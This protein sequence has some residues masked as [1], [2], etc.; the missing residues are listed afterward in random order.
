MTSFHY[1]DHVLITSGFYAGK[2][3]R[4]QSKLFFGLVYEVTVDT[5][6]GRPYFTRVLLTPWQMR[7]CKAVA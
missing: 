4:V 6:K 2:V 5:H 3:A 1:G 7:T